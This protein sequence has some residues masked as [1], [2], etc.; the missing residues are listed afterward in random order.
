MCF[1][2]NILYS[3]W[4]KK[5]SAIYFVYSPAGPLLCIGIGLHCTLLYAVKYTSSWYWRHPN[6]ELSNLSIY[7]RAINQAHVHMHAY[8][9][10]HTTSKNQNLFRAAGV[11]HLLC[12]QRNHNVFNAGHFLHFLCMSC[13][14]CL[15]QLLG[16]N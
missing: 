13:M 9:L 3:L 4:V 8:I 10:I 15:S 6:Y 7:P 16:R 5:I 11:L 12:L 1:I 14:R 2:E